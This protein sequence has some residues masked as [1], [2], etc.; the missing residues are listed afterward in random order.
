MLISDRVHK[1]EGASLRHRYRPHRRIALLVLLSALGLSASTTLASDKATP[2]PRPIGPLGDAC[3][4]DGPALVCVERADEP[5]LTIIERFASEG[6]RDVLLARND[7]YSD[8]LTGAARER[9]RR[10]I[11][12][13]NERSLRVLENA[14]RAYRHGDIGLSE[15]GRRR[16]LYR[17]AYANYRLGIEY[18]QR[19]QWF[20]PNEPRDRGSDDSKESDTFD[21]GDPGGAPTS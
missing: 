20:D 2:V 8:L 15:Y 7:D 4:F 1:R 13:N 14:A 21:D 9:L 10:S 17:A 12:I 5:L 19:A 6:T 3:L 16:A 18:Y 11:E